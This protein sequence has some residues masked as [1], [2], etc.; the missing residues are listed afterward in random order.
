[1]DICEIP[2]KPGV[3]DLL[4]HGRSIGHRLVLATSSSRRHVD[5]YLP[6]EVVA[7]FDLILTKESV[8]RRKPDPEIYRQAKASFPD[9][10]LVVLEDSPHGITAA[11]GA[12]ATCYLIPDLARCDAACRATC[13][14]VVAAARDLIG[15]LP[16]P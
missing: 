13:A 7:R 6:R 3:V 8:T 4:D 10:R 11:I 14:G 12:G 15:R 2:L 9:Q 5:R 16:P 1:M